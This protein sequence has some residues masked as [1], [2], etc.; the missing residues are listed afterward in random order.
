MPKKLN[1]Y[2]RYLQK[3]HDNLLNMN[4]KHENPWLFE[5]N[6]RREIR[7][8]VFLETE[9]SPS[10]RLHS[11]TNYQRMLIEKMDEIMEKQRQKEI[12]E[13]SPCSSQADPLRRKYTL[14]KRPSLIHS[15]DEKGA[16][17]MSSNLNVIPHANEI[18]DKKYIRTPTAITIKDFRHS[19]TA[20][21]PIPIRRTITHNLMF[22]RN[23]SDFE[24]SQIEFDQDFIL[25]TVFGYKNVRESKLFYRY[26]L[27]KEMIS[28]IHS[29]QSKEMTTVKAFSLS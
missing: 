3:R 17:P 14:A 10:P 6:S 26:T 25:C 23:K 21:S 7:N 24:D 1:R 19:E 5:R 2:I 29:F 20:E 15:I 8:I 13:G 28:L 9:E 27:K 16:V 22:L 12:A 4:N 11:N 18:I